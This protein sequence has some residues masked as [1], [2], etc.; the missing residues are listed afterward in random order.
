MVS[1]VTAFIARRWSVLP[2][3]LRVT[4]QPLQGGL[5][6]K[7]TRAQVSGSDGHRSVPPQLV[8]KELAAGFEREA[9][10]YEALWR[11]LSRP[12]AVQMF[13]REISARHTSTWKRRSRLSRGHGERHSPRVPYAARSRISMMVRRCRATPLCGTTKGNLRARLT[14]PSNSREKLTMHRVDGYGGDLAISGALSRRCRT[15]AIACSPAPRP[16]FTATCIPATSS[17]ADVRITK[18]Y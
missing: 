12:P 9:D 11:H 16:S 10:V 17:S 7:V 6:S 14:Q 15:F 2:G 8:I 13:G 18:S 1:R 3:L 5:E 4:V